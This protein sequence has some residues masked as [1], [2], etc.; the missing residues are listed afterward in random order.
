MGILSNIFHV[1]QDMEGS[2]VHARIIVPENLETSPDALKIT[3]LN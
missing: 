2:G 3:V 1:L